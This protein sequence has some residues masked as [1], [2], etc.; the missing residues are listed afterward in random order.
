MQFPKTFHFNFCS[1]LPAFLSPISVVSGL[2][3]SSGGYKGI[4]IMAEK[5]SL[6]LQC[7]RNC[8]ECNMLHYQ[9][10]LLSG[11]FCL[12]TYQNTFFTWYQ[13][14]FGSSTK[15][16]KLLELED[17]WKQA[18]Q[19]WLRLSRNVLCELHS[20]LRLMDHGYQVFFPVVKK[21]LQISSWLK[22]LICAM[23]WWNWFT[24]K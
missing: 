17:N 1:I 16:C 14:I 8:L 4:Q 10:L 6:C 19:R 24:P 23:R 15:F 9:N 7:A 12:Q 5:F 2:E 3:V 20:G 13:W 21:V 22:L 11:I 18:W